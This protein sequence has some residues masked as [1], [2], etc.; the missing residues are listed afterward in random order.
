[1]I[2]GDHWFKNGV[3]NGLHKREKDLKEAHRN[4]QNAALN[5]YL[6]GNIF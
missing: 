3:I 2:G 5:V 1:M 4:T 6:F